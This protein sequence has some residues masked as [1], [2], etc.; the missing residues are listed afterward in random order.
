MCCITMWSASSRFHARLRALVPEARIAIGHGQMRE[1]AL[2]D[3]M[4]DFYEGKY[5][6]LLCTTIIESGL[7][8]PNCNTLI[9]CEA[10]HFGLSQLYQLRGRVGRSNRL[11][12]AYLTVQPNKVLSETADKRLRAIREFTTFGSGFRIAMRDLEIRGAGNLLGAEQHGFL[13][14]VGYDMYCKLMEETVPG[15][16]GRNRRYGRH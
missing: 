6:V 12:Y 2:E 14:T 5:D 13:S 3:V 4:M 9:V 1:H 15:N 10:D 16:P 11:A 8:I 7:D